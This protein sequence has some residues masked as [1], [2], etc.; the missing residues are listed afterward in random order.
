VSAASRTALAMPDDFHSPSCVLTIKAGLRQLTSLGDLNGMNSLN[1]IEFQSRKAQ[2]P[3]TA[4]KRKN[5]MQRFGQSQ[6]HNYSLPRPQTSFGAFIAV[7]FCIVACLTTAAKGQNQEFP[8]YPKYQVM[9]VVY[10]PPGSASSVTYGSSTLVGSS[11]SMI[12]N[13]TSD[14][15]STTSQ[16]TGFNLFGFGHSTTNTT[17][18]SWG[19][20][21]TATKTYNMETVAGNS[22][23]TMGPVSSSLGVNHDND[24]I[25]IWLNPVVLASVAT[26]GTNN[27]P[28]YGLNWAGL[29]FNSCDLTDP[30]DQVN[31]LQLMNGCDPN[32]YPFPDI[33][34]IPVWCLKNPYYPGQSCA[35]WQPFTSRSWDLT[36]WGMDS[37]GVPLGPGLTLQDYAD[38]LRADPFITQTNAND[39]Y[40]VDH[41]CHPSYGV[42]FDPNDTETIPDSTKFPANVLYVGTG[43]PTTWPANFC[44]TTAKTMSRFDPYGTVQFP[45][46]GPNG[47]PQT[48]SGTFTYST[49]LTSGQSATTTT[50]HSYNQNTTNSFA[51]EVSFAP[52]L[53]VPGAVF[54][55]NLSAGF[56]FSFSNGNGY[57]YSSAQTNSGS[58]T[59]GTTDSAAYSITGPQSSDNYTGPAVFNVYKDDVYNTFA[60]YSDEQRLLPPVQLSIVAG[61]APISVSAVTT[62]GSVQVGSSSAAQSITLTNNSPYLMTVAAP[63]VTFS[64]PGFQIVPGTDGCSNTLLGPYQSPNPPNPP[65]TCTLSIELAPV[66]SDAPNTIQA[67]YPVHANLVAAGTENVVSWENILVTSTGV[68]ASGTATPAASTCTNETPYCN[69]GATLLPSVFTFANETWPTVTTQTNVY[70]FKNYYSSTLVVSGVAL[71]D[72]VDYTVTSDNCTGKPVPS[73]TTCTFTLTYLPKASGTLNV[74]ITVSATLNGFSTPVAFAGAAAL[75]QSVGLSATGSS[76]STSIPFPNLS[77]SCS[78]TQTITNTSNSYPLTVTSVNGTNGFGGSACSGSI[79][80]NGSCQASVFYSYPGS[81]CSGTVPFSCSISG[82]LTVSGV[83]NGSAVSTTA[84]A[85]CNIEFTGFAIVHLAGVEQ[86]KTVT[87]PAQHGKAA[88]SLAGA[89]K[90][91]FKGTRKVVL[92]VGGFKANASYTSSDTSATVAKALA[93]AVNVSGSPAIATVN[94]A[95]IHLTSKVAGKSGNIAYSVAG[96]ADF[97][98]SP[99]KGSLAGG[100][101]ATKNTTYDGGSV[102]ASVGSVAASASW[103]KGS[104]P[105]TIATA[106]A[107]A[108]TAAGKGTFVAASSGSD[109]TITPKKSGPKPAVNASVN[110]KMGFS[111]T[112]FATTTN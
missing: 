56:N 107:S 78:G 13:S 92:T 20:A 49:T 98:G 106:L 9:G 82:T 105:Q 14:S 43:W 3:H 96:T 100:A 8:I 33:I 57:S 61:Q 58:T 76:M 108:L 35:Q 36:P 40:A 17:S 47:E 83:E 111:P 11:H 70:T 25:Y 110:D 18:D 73:L 39:A 24:V 59:N 1:Q 67:S 60:F 46:P 112:S 12:T 32:Q 62:F 2:P 90:T 65:Y 72:A 31:F 7:C 71:S 102:D 19:V 50:S 86:S 51:F 28:P 34:G 88:V 26:T 23:S 81:G 42:N 54:A 79:P 37:N 27:A 95:T 93:A 87:K 52:L 80:V 91:P 30:T 6:N 53:G 63:A 104:T 29:Q 10:A 77:G 48:Y 84:G 103:G 4:R 44:G 16:T 94:G 68:V 22:V 66:V 99:A 85:S 75:V 41:Y 89:V 15:V 55:S 74:K 64:D 45:V 109:V 38:I 97:A 101:P 21:S 69:V 5:T